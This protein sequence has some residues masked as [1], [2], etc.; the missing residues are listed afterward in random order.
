M[1]KKNSYL[2]L[3]LDPELDKESQRVKKGAITFSIVFTAL[4]VIAVGGLVFF[5]LRF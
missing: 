3:C 4:S 5:L 2:R 1:K